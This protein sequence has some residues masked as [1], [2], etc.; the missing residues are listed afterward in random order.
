MSR[1]TVC[2]REIDLKKF[3]HYSEYLGRTYYFCS[4]KCKTIFDKNPEK[5]R[6]KVIIRKKKR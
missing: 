2:K 1:D 4:N 6:E 3:I 5:Y